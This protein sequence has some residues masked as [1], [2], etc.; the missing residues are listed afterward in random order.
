MLY[1]LVYLYTVDSTM[2]RTAFHFPLQLQTDDRHANRP[3]AGQCDLPGYPSIDNGME[4][5][6]IEHITKIFVNAKPCD[7]Q[8]HQDG[9][10]VL[11]KRGSI[12]LDVTWRKDPWQPKLGM[13][14]GAVEKVQVPSQEYS[15]P[16]MAVNNETSFSQIVCKEK[17]YGFAQTVRNGKYGTGG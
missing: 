5:A 2:F 17:A 15:Q 9:Q 13:D 7:R 16:R 3:W 12:F 10:P 6:N 14:Q 1:Y 4:K 8:D 11:G